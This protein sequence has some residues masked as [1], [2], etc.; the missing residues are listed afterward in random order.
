MVLVHGDLISLVRCGLVHACKSTRKLLL[1]YCYV[2]HPSM[3]HDL[4][5]IV[6]ARAFC[7]TKHLFGRGVTDTRPCLRLWLQLFLKTMLFLLGYC[8]CT[9]GSKLIHVLST[10]R[11]RCRCDQIP[12]RQTRSALVII[13]CDVD[14][15][16]V[17]RRRA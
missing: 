15:C 3:I 5:E 1:S 10:A 7:F 2:V 9:R 16:C 17:E 11:V 12:P 4:R 14:S 8:R 13:I 6:S